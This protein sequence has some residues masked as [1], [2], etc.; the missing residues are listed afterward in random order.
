M[1][2]LKQGKDK[3][4]FFF[5]VNL[6]KILS[7]TKN[8]GEL[9]GRFS[10]EEELPREESKLLPVET[11]V[12]TTAA[13]LAELVSADCGGV[14]GAISIGACCLSV[15]SVSWP[16]KPSEET[17]ESSLVSLLL[18][19]SFHCRIDSLPALSKALKM[20]L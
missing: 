18:M 9:Y 17:F 19:F 2:N 15:R 4:E 7:I 3:I 10:I 20:I 1:E 13:L 11:E 6:Y 5:V 8:E 16:F 12:S 14:S